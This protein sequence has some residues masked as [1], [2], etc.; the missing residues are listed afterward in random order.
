M[1]IK[2]LEGKLTHLLQEYQEFADNVAPEEIGRLAREFYTESFEKEGFTDTS[3]QEW[4]EVKRRIEPRRPDLAAAKRG[5]LINTGNLKRS[6]TYETFKG[7]VVVRAEAFSPPGFDYA[8]VH[9]WGTARVPQRQFL[10]ESKQLNDKIIEELK[11]KI[12]E[13]NKKI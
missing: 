5:I 2:E 1:T 6:L 10:G 12:E 11:K 9:N 7:L 13:I 8:R 4:P 3:F